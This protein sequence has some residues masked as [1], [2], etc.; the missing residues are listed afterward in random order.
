MGFSDC[1]KFPLNY[2]G[3]RRFGSLVEV[4]TP[5]YFCGWPLFQG[6]NSKVESFSD[7]N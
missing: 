4:G 7:L 1:Q 3:V 6:I 2:F 5:R